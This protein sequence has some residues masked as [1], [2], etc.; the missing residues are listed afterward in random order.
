[1]REHPFHLICTAL[2]KHRHGVSLEHGLPPTGGW[3]MGI[4]RLVM[5]LTDSTSAS[6]GDQMYALR[7]DVACDCRYQGGSSLSR[8]EAYRDEREYGDGSAII[9]AG[10]DLEMRG[11]C[12]MSLSC[13]R[14]ALW[15]LLLDLHT[16]KKNPMQIGIIKGT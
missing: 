2:I 7:T 14:L 3:G 13:I 5:F 6:S 16:Q 9:G 1:M 12:C 11:L 10:V 15:V 4:D 8:N